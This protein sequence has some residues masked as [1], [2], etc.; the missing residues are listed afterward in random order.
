[1]LRLFGHVERKD[2]NDWV[3]RCIT[4]EVEGVRQRG[5]PKNIPSDFEAR[6]KDLNHIFMNNAAQNC[7]N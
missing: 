5:R 2:D 1:M 3:K 4:W 6:S 7:R